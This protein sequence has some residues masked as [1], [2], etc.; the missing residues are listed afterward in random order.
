MGASARADVPRVNK[1]C[2]SVKKYLDH[3]D[4]FICAV[5][6]FVMTCVT[7]TNVLSRYILHMSI[8]ASEEIA[9]LL[10]ILLSLMGSA[11]AVKRRAHLGLTI[12][13]DHLPPKAQSITTIF[14]Y[15][16]GIVFCGVLAY[17]GTIM[18]IN[19]Y[20]LGI[21]TISM[22][23]P[24]WIFCLFIPIGA[25]SIILRFAQQIFYEIKAMRTNDEKEG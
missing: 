1:G 19:E 17:E 24:E 20:K 6:L 9:T 13:T 14:G 25:V 15:L 8:S 4:E 10:F 3:I 18:T 5:L 7:F 12:I 21:L 2:E 23:W 16:C 11:I 22:N